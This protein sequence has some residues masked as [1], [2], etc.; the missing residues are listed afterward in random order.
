[1]AELV[2][3]ILKDAQNTPVNHTFTPYD[4]V[5]GVGILTEVVDGVPEAANTLSI[6]KSN[7]SSGNVTHVNIK[8]SVPEVVVETINGVSRSR[9]ERT[10]RFRGE[11]I[12]H[13]SSTLQERRDLVAMVASAL[14][15]NNQAFIMDTLVSLNGVR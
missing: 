5:G 8:L 6:G 15:E 11:F 4:K 12:Y 10:A 14:V 13:K 7:S 3:V 2:N 9:L 1:M